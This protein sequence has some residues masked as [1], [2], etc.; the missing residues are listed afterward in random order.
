[1]S[2]Q[3]SDLSDVKWYLDHV[4]PS[5]DD[6]FKQLNYQRGI[7]DQNLVDTWRE[8]GYHM[9]N[10]T[11]DTVEGQ[12][13]F[14]WGHSILQKLSW[15]HMVTRMFR[16]NTGDILPY[17][18]DHYRTFRKIYHINDPRCICRCV[19]FMEDWMTGHYFE[20]DGHAVLHWRA[21]DCVIWRN[22]VPHMVANI[23]IQPRYTM[24]ITGIKP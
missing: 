20:I 10:L 17:H 24:Q 8:Q 21:G 9:M 4:D 11:G 15:K 2:S 6:S 16:M 12:R 14:I 22:D 3:K 18:V 23:G 19:V 13:D 5:W 1:M 7:P